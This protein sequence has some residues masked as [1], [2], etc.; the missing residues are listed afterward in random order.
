M[1]PEGTSV[2]ANRA[3]A[4]CLLILGALLGQ[5]AE[6]WRG[7]YVKSDIRG[8]L[9][10]PNVQGDWLEVQ[11]AFINKGNRQ[12][13]VT[14]VRVVF[15]VNSGQFPVPAKEYAWQNPKDF[16]VTGIPVVL[17]PGD[18]RLVILRGKLNPET[19]GFY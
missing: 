7:L 18:I 2:W 12:G 4:V 3:F 5:G 17:N 9:L 10:S 16:S 19:I 11:L 13:A 1:A 6:Y 14:N 8:H 15:P